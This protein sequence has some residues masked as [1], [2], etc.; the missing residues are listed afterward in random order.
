MPSVILKSGK[1]HRLVGGHSWVYSG[2][3]AKITGDPDDGE[4]V[5]IRDHKERYLGT[6]LIN[7][8]SQIAVRRF[9]IDKDEINMAFLRK[10]IEAAN[11]ARSG[12]T[13]RVVFSE[14]DQL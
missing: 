5:D 14:S 13:Y 8:K 3:I 4:A 2:E 1:E 6:G 11:A 7:L 9:T 10:R 12:D